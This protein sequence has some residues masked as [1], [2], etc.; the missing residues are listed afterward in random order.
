MVEKAK[1]KVLLAGF[2]LDYGEMAVIN[3][4]IDNYVEKIEHRIG[5]E[6]IKLTLK[7]SRRGKSFLHEVKGTLAVGGKQFKTEKTDYNLLKVL[8]EVFEKLM[9]E[10]EH[11]RRTSR[12]TR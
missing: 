9:K 2:D 10:A 1:G 5:F 11:N 3:N 8:S 7:K 6:E 4:I 12:Q